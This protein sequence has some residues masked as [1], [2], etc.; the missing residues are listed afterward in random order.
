MFNLQLIESIKSIDSLVI[1]RLDKKTKLSTDSRSYTSGYLF[2]ALKGE[3][4]DGFRY[5][6]QVLDKGC[7]LIVYTNTK[8]NNILADKLKEEFKDTTFIATDSTLSFL[9]ELA[10]LRIRQWQKLNKTKRTIGITGSNGKTTNKEMLFHLLNSIFPN[11]VHCTRGNFNNH[12]GVPLT[13]LD[14]EDHHDI[15]IVEMGTNHMGE[16]SVLCDIAN[17]DSGLIT[18]I[19]D[20]HLEFFKSRENIFKE[21]SSLFEYIKK[22]NNKSSKFIIN[23]SDEFLSKLK[24]KFSVTI[25]DENSD[26]VFSYSNSEAIIKGKSNSVTLKN[27]K[28]NERFNFFNLALTFLLC[29]ELFPEKK[30]MLISAANNFELPKNNRSQWITRNNKTIYLDA[31]NANPSSMKSSLDSYSQYL[32]EN[33]I[34]PEKVYFIIGDM[35]ELGDLAKEMHQDITKK[36]ISI[37]AKNIAFVGKY[38]SYYGKGHENEYDIFESKE[39]LLKN[40]PKILNKAEYFFIKASRSLQ[41]ESLIDIT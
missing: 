22:I 23:N 39:E 27:D 12:I 8:T 38:S 21:K 10:S 4:F 36:L 1:K 37:G 41:L 11:K 24:S 40:W 34:V 32:K 31:Y 28:M 29:Y 15:S 26:H 16:I 17:P 3:N 18:N 20:A 2:I 7:P 13:I 14:L 6:K 9:Q 5:A 25:G 30:E 35:N 33:S 19:G